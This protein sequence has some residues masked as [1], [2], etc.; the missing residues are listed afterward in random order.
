[1]VADVTTPQER[2]AATDSYYTEL[3]NLRTYKQQISFGMHVIV[4]MGAFYAF[5]HVAGIAITD[6]KALHPLCGL[7]LMIGALVMET[8]LFII[9]TTVPPKLHWEVEKKRRDRHARAE[10]EREEKERKES[11]KEKDKD[12]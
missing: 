2:A 1:M 4:T 10:E 12:A 6:N 9:R 7:V 3:G 8:T 5:G 11:G